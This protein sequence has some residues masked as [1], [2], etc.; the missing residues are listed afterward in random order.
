MGWLD[1]LFKNKNKKKMQYAQMMNG[2]TPFFSSFGNDIYK[3]DVVQQAITCIILEIKK[4][5]P[6][7]V[8]G[9]DDDVI[10]ISDSSIQK[11]LNRPNEIMTKSDFLEKIMWSLM[12]HYN[13]F[14][15][16]V[17]KSWKDKNGNEKRKY[18]AL[19]PVQPTNVTFEEDAM[20]RIWIRMQFLNGYETVLPYENVIH[21]KYNYSI[22]EFMGGNEFGVPDHETLIQTLQINKDMMEGIRGAMKSSFAING[23]VK[24]NTM[25]DDGK[26]EQALVDLENKLKNSDSGFLPLDLKA[27]FIPLKKEIKMVD[28]DV[29]KFIDEKILRTWGISLAILTGDYTKEQYQ[30]F[31]QKALEPIIISLSDAFTK[32]LLTDGEI[33]HGNKIMFYP[34]DL[35][36]MNTDQTLE[37]I[38][39]LGD[40]GALYENE[41]RVALGLKPLKELQGIRMQSL[42]YVNSDIAEEYQ[43]KNGNASRRKGDDEDAQV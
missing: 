36:F 32:A 29:L 38:R 14:I 22:N 20:N 34:K 1:F 3:S 42:N 5:K 17:Y 40:S 43:I 24:F 6:L 25:L 2:Y 15:I 31:Y 16:P 13:A 4:L 35:I 10:P 27:E 26:T 9:E 12:L 41:K 37:M 33:G 39:L 19:Y 8:R 18:T 30:A 21:I 23:V 28:S 11:V 7:H